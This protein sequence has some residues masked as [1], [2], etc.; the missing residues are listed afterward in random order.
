MNLVG[1]LS[2]PKGQILGQNS[3]PSGRK[4]SFLRKAKGSSLGQIN[5]VTRPFSKPS[6]HWVMDADLGA[7]K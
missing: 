4:I 1:S 5:N 2:S 6:R 3:S 7:E